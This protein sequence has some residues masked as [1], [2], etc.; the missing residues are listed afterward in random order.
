MFIEF[1]VLFDKVFIE[2]SLNIIDIFTF[3]K[4]VLELRENKINNKRIT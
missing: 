3:N 1:I 2:T 4:S